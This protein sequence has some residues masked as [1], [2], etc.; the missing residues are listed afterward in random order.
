MSYKKFWS[1][2]QDQYI[3]QGL[4]RNGQI[5]RQREWD[6]KRSQSAERLTDE[7]LSCPINVCY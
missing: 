3:G 1:L 4:K 5:N 7:L 6:R 2:Q